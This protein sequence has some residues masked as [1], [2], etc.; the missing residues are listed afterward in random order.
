MSKTQVGL[1]QYTAPV[2]GSY[3]LS[4]KIV[5]AVPTGK[6]VEVTNPK[7]RWWTPWRSK[8]VVEHEHAVE[9]I[10]VGSSLIKLNK[11]DE[12]YLKPNVSSKEGVFVYVKKTD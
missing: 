1:F 7:Y 12:F 10:D 4:Y 9:T 6:T 11:G 5:K 8:T 2:S 3:S